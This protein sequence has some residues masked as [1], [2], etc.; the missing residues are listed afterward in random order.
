MAWRLAE[1][2]KRTEEEEKKEATQFL[3]NPQACRA[4]LSGF[5]KQK[6]K[7]LLDRLR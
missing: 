7:V 3:L 2:K 5:S 4:L 6:N 1:E